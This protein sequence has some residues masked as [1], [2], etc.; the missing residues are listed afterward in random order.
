MVFFLKKIRHPYWGR[1]KETAKSR[2]HQKPRGWA[3][4]ERDGSGTRTQSSSRGGGG[5]FSAP[6][7][8]G[9]TGKPFRRERHGNPPSGRRPGVRH[10]FTSHSSFFLAKHLFPPLSPPQELR[11]KPQPENRFEHPEQVKKHAHRRRF[12]LY[13]GFPLPLL[14]FFVQPPPKAPLIQK[15]IFFDLLSC[16]FA[17]ILNQVGGLCPFEVRE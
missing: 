3:G 6:E 8:I 15:I 4:I 1:G 5:E 13:A 9:M 11:S 17:V 7:Q 14:P 12:P 10:L 2:P 16:R